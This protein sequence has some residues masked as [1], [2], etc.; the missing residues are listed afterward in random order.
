M[1]RLNLTCLLRSQGDVDWHPDGKGPTEEWGLNAAKFMVYL[2]P[3]SADAGSLHILPT[4]HLLRGEAR[5]HFGKGIAASTFSDVPG[6]A[7]E[8]NPGDLII[9]NI[10]AWHGSCGGGSNRR[11]IN[12]DYFEA[13]GT[14]NAKNSLRQL[15]KTHAA[16]RDK[17][18]LRR[19]PFN[20]SNE[21]LS[22]PERSPVRARWIR[23]L[24]ELETYFDGPHVTEG[25]ELLPEDERVERAQARRLATLLPT[26]SETASL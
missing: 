6:T 21:W 26:M 24:R 20:Y 2:D 16:G 25:N 12:L 19:W 22:N 5:D 15:G 13:P 10:H 9:F 14:I 3:V 18:V 4:T 23:Q 1:E 7:L 8:T 17:P 11:I